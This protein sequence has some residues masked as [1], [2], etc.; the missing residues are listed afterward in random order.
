MTVFSFAFMTRSGARIKGSTLTNRPCEDDRVEQNA[1]DA[2]T[3]TD[4]GA[5]PIGNAWIVCDRV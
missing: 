3:T 1:K 4:L 2:K 5:A